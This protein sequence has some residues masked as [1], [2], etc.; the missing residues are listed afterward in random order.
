[1][2]STKANLQ[3]SQNASQPQKNTHTSNEDIRATLAPHSTALRS[4]G[5]RGRGIARLESRASPRGSFGHAAAGRSTSAGVGAG[6]R[7]G[8]AGGGSAGGGVGAGRFGGVE[9]SGV[10]GLAVG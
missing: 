5:S 10:V 1:M 2:T 8:A 6:G 3:H 4:G 7:G 9:G